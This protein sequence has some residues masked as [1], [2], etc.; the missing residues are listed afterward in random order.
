MPFVGHLTPACRRRPSRVLP[1]PALIA[2]RAT[3]V[4][5]APAQGAARH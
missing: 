5:A 1:P 3:Q 2:V 4:V